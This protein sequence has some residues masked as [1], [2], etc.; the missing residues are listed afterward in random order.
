[1]SHN[2]EGRIKDVFEDNLEEEL[3][4]ISELI[5]EYNFISMVPNNSDF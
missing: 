4:R 1:M 2:Q 5:E 3:R